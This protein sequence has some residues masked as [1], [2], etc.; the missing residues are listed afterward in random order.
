MQKKLNSLKLVVFFLMGC[1]GGGSEDSGLIDD[2]PSS[3]EP[4]SITSESSYSITE[5]RRKIGVVQV[6]DPDSENLNFSIDG[7]DSD[8]ILVNSE[9][10]LRF[11]VGRDFEKPS[12]ADLDNVYSVTLVVSDG[13]S[14]TKAEIL[15]EVL[16]ALEQEWDQNDLDSNVIE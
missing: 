14:E 3:N 16:D 2:L 9:G 4:P 11:T 15:I 5:N 8:Q 1:G 12:D 7:P 10:Q 6:R 13:Q